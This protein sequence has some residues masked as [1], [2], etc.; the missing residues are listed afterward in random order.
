MKRIS[1][2]TMANKKI[3]VVKNIK[4]D[5]RECAASLYYSTLVCAYSTKEKAMGTC[6]RLSE[7]RYRA[8]SRKKDEIY[9]IMPYKRHF[10]G[11]A[12]YKRIEADSDNVQNVTFEQFLVVEVELDPGVNGY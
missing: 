11:Y 4:R 1:G 12:I 2:D 8:L 9:E 6:K 7:K 10:E 5:E 3:F